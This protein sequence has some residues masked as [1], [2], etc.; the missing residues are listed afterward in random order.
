MTRKV[1]IALM[2]GL[3]PV[4]CGSLYA[5]SSVRSIG[6]NM[7]TIS[8]NVYETRGGE[9]GAQAHA[10]TEAKD[11]CTHLGE[12][13]TTS[14]YAAGQLGPPTEPGSSGTIELRFRCSEGGSQTGMGDDTRLPGEHY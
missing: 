3:V 10:L 12:Q 9:A 11:Y 1:A 8:A 14:M 5:P 4:G 13:L 6:P 7:Y 2:V